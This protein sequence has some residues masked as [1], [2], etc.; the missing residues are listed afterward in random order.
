MA[1]RNIYKPAT[2]VWIPPIST[3]QYKITVE[4]NGVEEDITNICSKII[5]EDYC[6]ESIGKFSF[7]IYNPSETYTNKWVGNEIFRYYKSYTN[8]T[9]LFFRGRLEKISKQGYKLVVDGRSESLKFMTTYVSKQYTNTDSGTI[10]LDL[11]NTYATGYTGNGVNLSGVNI[12]VNWYRKPFW[13]CVQELCTAAGFECRVDADLDFHYFLS[14]S[15]DNEDDAIVH[16]LNLLELE[17]FTPDISQVRNRIKV[18]GA[19]QNGTQIFYTANDTT[20]QGLYGVKEESINDDNITNLTQAEEIAQFNLELLKDPPLTG[21]VKSAFLLG[22]YKAGEN[23]T[24][25]APSEGMNPGL[26]IGVGYKDELNFDGGDVTTTIYIN[27]EPR[28][29]SHILKNRIEQENNNKS[30]PLNPYDMDFTNNFEFTSSVGTLSNAI[31]S[32]SV[33][34]ASSIGGTWISPVKVLPSNIIEAYLIVNGTA[35]GDITVQIS[36]NNGVSHQTIN[37]KEKIN[38]TTTIGTNLIIK[39]TLNS[40]AAQISNISLQY[41]LG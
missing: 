15:V 11:I 27:K 30:V 14:G 4:K 25:S 23:I 2:Y 34:K 18:S 35:T 20:S 6:T 38:V 24:L 1:V 12:T 8:T 41:K 26:Y 5:I 21:S 9:T 7:E 31:I 29:V 37:N 36:G 22:T 32:N 19:I 13:T 39:V 10:L 40:T 16:Y 3:P 17:E 28:K 33:L